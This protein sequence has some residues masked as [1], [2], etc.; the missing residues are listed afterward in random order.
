MHT[1]QV[2]P[3][4]HESPAEIA[5]PDHASRIRRPVSPV[6]D[7]SG[8]LDTLV[9]VVLLAPILIVTLLVAIL[10]DPATMSALT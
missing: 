2:S 8:R 10:M 5:T 4:L 9:H 7:E 1:D 6:P 3:T